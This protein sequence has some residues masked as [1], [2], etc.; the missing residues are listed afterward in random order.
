MRN[1]RLIS[2]HLVAVAFVAACSDLT[3]PDSHRSTARSGAT[4]ATVQIGQGI[5]YY[6]VGSKQIPLE[7]D[8]GI[9]TVE[10][11]TPGQ[12][13]IQARGILGPLGITV[14]DGGEFFSFLHHRMLHHSSGIVG[15]VLAALRA[16]SRFR[17]VAPGYRYPGTRIPVRLLNRLDIKFREGVSA[18]VIDSFTKVLGLRTL[19]RP[20]PDSGFFAYRFAY[21]QGVDP[22][23]FANSLQQN[24]L[25][26]W[27][28]PDMQDGANV[29]NQAPSDPYYSLQFY[30]KNSLILYGVPVD[31]DI[32]SVW[33]FATGAGVRITV[34]DDG[35]DILH[36]ELVYAFSGANTYDAYPPPPGQTDSPYQ[37]YVSDSTDFH[38][39]AVAG[40]IFA[41]HNGIGMAGAAPGALI[42]VVR[43]F[44]DG[45]G[46]SNTLIADGY[47]RAWAYMGSD[48][49]SSS[50]SRTHIPGSINCSDEGSSQVTA[51]I[52]SAAA[53]GRNGKGTV[54]VFSAGNPSDRVHNYVGPVCWPGRLS[55]VLA[56]GAIDRYGAVSNYSPEGPELD[57]VAPSS[58]SYTGCFLPLEVLTTDRYGSAGC[59]DGPS[60]DENY[61]SGWFG[62]TSA[63]APQ[64]S[65]IAALILQMSPTWTG[66]Y[67][68]SRI[69]QTAIP[70]GLSTRF[71]AGKVSAAHAVPAPPPPPLTIT[72]TGPSS[73]RPTSTCLWTAASSSGTAPF[74]YSWY[75]N[76]VGVNNGSSNPAELIYQNSGSS[77]T[78]SVDVYDAVGASGSA[79]KSVTIS[80]T[81]PVCHF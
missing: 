40:M 72:L 18:T 47:N 77:F 48:V 64:V 21:P 52:Q 15:P 14:E 25:L 71:G 76:G 50:W 41:P 81:A 19:R 30:L 20:L 8:P 26:E 60:G 58:A 53:N 78:V 3:P 59:N 27:S 2:W 55:E 12:A 37:P 63:S 38:G 7:I 73:V 28:S 56:V 57:V 10:E 6:A 1:T 69:K 70:W 24:P 45:H 33:P 9:L 79:S 4:N 13:V 51:A 65:A 17:F 42:N 80:S 46:T 44:R 74:T 39:T 68:Q 31:I 22:L 23:E 61:T 62:G 35:V 49:I 16:D 66:S 43:I 34:V 75:V 67:I 5:Q 29:L 32:E 11:D 36:P 54:M